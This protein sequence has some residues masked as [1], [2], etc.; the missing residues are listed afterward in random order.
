MPKDKLPY[1]KFWV[2]DFELDPNVRVM[3][4]EEVG[5][6]IRILNRIWMDGSVPDDPSLIARL[7]GADPEEVKRGYPRVR[8]CLVESDTSGLTHPR[9]ELE[10]QH[11]TARASK[12]KTAAKVRWKEQSNANAMHDDDAH[13][14]HLQCK[15][16]HNQNQNQNHSQSP[17][18]T[19]TISTTRDSGTDVGQFFEER[20][21]KHPNKNQRNIALQYMA[22][23][24][25]IETREVQQRFSAGHDA[26][27]NSELW[28]WKYGARA[29][30]LAQF[31][32]D[33]G[34]EYPPPDTQPE[35]SVLKPLN[36]SSL[37]L[38][39][40]AEYIPDW[41]AALERESSEKPNSPIEAPKKPQDAA[42]ELPRG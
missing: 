36:V 23:I 15:S 2:A 9:L 5:L 4:L 16:I 38:D 33:R 18:L 3:T 7:I 25:G 41:Q 29:P 34:W 35:P 20:F 12:L 10:R 26:W 14:M 31:I 11:A 27:L 39:P 13:A 22:V 32:L 30:T 37:G 24:D 17:S 1:Y 21:K 8:E 42:E 40:Y 6:Y 19:E 28:R